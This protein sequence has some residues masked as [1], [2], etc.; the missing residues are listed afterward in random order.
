MLPFPLLCVGKMGEGKREK[1][2]W[3]LEVVKDKGCRSK[4]TE[5]EVVFLMSFNLS[6]APVFFF[7]ECDVGLVVD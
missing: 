7:Y 2:I 1:L 6:A 5:K 3:R 4:D